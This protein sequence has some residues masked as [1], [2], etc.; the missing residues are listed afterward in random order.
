MGKLSNLLTKTLNFLVPARKKPNFTS[1]LIVA[2]GS[3]TRMGDGVSKQLFKIC[4]VPTVVHTLLAF[5]RTPEIDEIIVVA[6]KDEIELYK[7]FKS[8]YGITKLKKAVV[9]GE[10]RQQSA[11]NGFL[12]ISNESNYVA[13]HDGARCLIT[14]KEISAVCQAAYTH[15]AATA[16]TRA[17]DTIKLATKDGFIEKTIDRSTVWHAQTPQIFD[18]SLYRAA[19]AIGQRD[20]V[21]VT[22]DCSLAEYIEHPV[23]LVECSK[24]N[25][26]IT[27][28]DDIPHAA[29]IIKKRSKAKKE[30][31]E[32]KK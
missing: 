31:E 24:S 6:K 2:G 29:A 19:L 17:T 12:A 14:P 26:K 3:S 30:N 28:A 5:E 25:I 10:S 15:G 11:K 7:E 9:G 1:A 13:I 21:K 22:D 16:A 8:L 20:G 27:T 4:G 32:D 23:K 18:N